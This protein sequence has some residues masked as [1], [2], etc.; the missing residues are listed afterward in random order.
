[1]PQGAWLCY[2]AV[3]TKDHHPRREGDRQAAGNAIVSADG[4][5]KRKPLKM[6]LSWGLSPDFCPQ[7]FS[8]AKAV[9]NQIPYADVD[10]RQKILV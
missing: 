10:N 3:D 1:M 9:A 6:G 2:N 7:T 8:T 5:E 4:G